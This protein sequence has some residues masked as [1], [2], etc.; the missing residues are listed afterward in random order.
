MSDKKLTIKQQRF[1]SEYI[2][3]GNGAQSAIKAGYSKHCA[4]QIAK[5]NVTKPYIKQKIETVMSEE[6]AKLGI[7][8]EYV[9][10]NIKNISE[11]ETKEPSSVVLKANELLGKHLKLFHD[12]EMDVTLKEHRDTLRQLEDLE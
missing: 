10:G 5:E 12:G 6:A 11:R 2:K 4:R 1:V 3:T 8:V 7:T 9:L